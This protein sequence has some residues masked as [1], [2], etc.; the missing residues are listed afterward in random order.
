MYRRWTDGVETDR[1]M[2][3]SSSQATLDSQQY[4]F[5]STFLF[6]RV[7]HASFCP[8]QLLDSLQRNGTELQHPLPHYN[9][10]LHHGPKAMGPTNQD[11]ET[12]KP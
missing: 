8:E 9:R 10:L 1:Q 12:L 2:A 3:I 6:S 11:P 7:V 5:Q 4:H